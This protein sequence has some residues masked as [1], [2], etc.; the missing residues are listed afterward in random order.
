MKTAG[1]IDLDQPSDLG[2]RN[3]DFEQGTAEWFDWAEERDVATTELVADGA[4]KHGGARSLRLDIT[5]SRTTGRAESI[6]IGQDGYDVVRGEV[7]LVTLWV[8]AVPPR[9]GR[10]Y[11]NTRQP[12]WTSY[13][14]SLDREIPA[15][16][17]RVWAILQAPV[18]DDQVGLR[19]ELHDLG[20]GSVW[21][22]EFQWVGFAPR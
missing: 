8:K 13:A 5:S 17:Q 21:L 19:V 14:S 2:I 3:A 11:I 9:V 4:E 20:S 12:P 6:E 15:Q 10:V 18:D 16:W 1:D 22:D 7:G